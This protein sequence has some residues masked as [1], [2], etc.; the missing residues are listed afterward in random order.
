MLII[1]IIT[2]II[3]ISIIIVIRISI[4]IIAIITIIIIII[5]IITIII[6][7]W[8]EERAE[9]T[10]VPEDGDIGDGAVGKTTMRQVSILVSF[11]LTNGFASAP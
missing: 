8:V 5:T 1:I 2:I 9:L 7:R 6:T 11:I 10:T 3:I 4:I